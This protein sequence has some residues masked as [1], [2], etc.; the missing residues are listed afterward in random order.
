MDYI[1][2]DTSRKIM[3]LT[4]SFKG[5]MLTHSDSTAMRS[6]VTL[7]PSIDRWLSEQGSTVA[8]LDCIGVCIGPGSFTGIRIGVTTAKALSYAAG[9]KLV[10]FDTLEMLAYKVF[11]ILGVKDASCVES[12]IAI[13]D[14]GNG[15]Y[16]SAVFAPAQ[17][18]LLIRLLAP[19]VLNGPQLG[20]FV[21]SVD[22]P[23]VIIADCDIAGDYPHINIYKAD[24]CHDAVER[25]MSE[26][27]SG[28]RPFLTHS[29]VEPLYVQLSQAEKD[30]C[31]KD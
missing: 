28:I 6:S 30:L 26:A 25:I 9:V 19:C 29:E 7:M 5:G 14:S 16:Y 13:L 27:G 10:A 20:R 15:N 12:V 24:K 22:E 31:A 21:E 2:I 8:S 3:E 17:D 18:G 1:A 23:C 4:G 11:G